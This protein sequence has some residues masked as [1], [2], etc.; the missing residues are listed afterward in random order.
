MIDFTDQIAIVT[1]AGRDGVRLSKLP[2]LWTA[3]W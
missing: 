2:G 1:G 3:T